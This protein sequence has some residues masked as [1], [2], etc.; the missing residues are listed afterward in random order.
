MPLGAAALAYIGWV[1]IPILA[2]LLILYASYR[3]TIQA[4]PNSG[5]ACTVSRL[6]P[7]HPES[8]PDNA[9][10]RRRDER[11]RCPRRT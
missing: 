9:G 10:A 11:G 3:Q 4:Y 7:L 1:M 5:G 8:L 2:L 6:N